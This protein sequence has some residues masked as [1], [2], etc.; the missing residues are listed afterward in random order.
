M[1][2]WEESAVTV[3]VTWGSQLPYAGI[4]RIRFKGS[5]SACCLQAPL[6][7]S[8]S[9]S[10]NRIV[11]FPGA[12]SEYRTTPSP[13]FDASQSVLRLKSRTAFLG[14]PFAAPIPPLT[15]A[16]RSPCC[17]RPLDARSWLTLRQYELDQVDCEG[18]SQPLPAVER[19]TPSETDGSDSSRRTGRFQ[20]MGVKTVDA[21]EQAVLATLWIVAAPTLDIR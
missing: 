6:A 11:A 18:V 13:A 17:E 7:D 12:T 15:L 9:Y 21:P 2:R 19:G 10:G 3:R 20:Q 16:C 4:N 14:R 5:F 8:T 1:G